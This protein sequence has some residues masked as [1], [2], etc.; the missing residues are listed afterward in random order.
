MKL[1]WL[2]TTALAAV[3]AAG[4]AQAA[5]MPVKA[6]VY[7]APFNWTGFYIGAHVGAGW[8]TKEWSAP[9]VNSPEFGPAGSYNLNGFLGGGQIGYNWQSG[10]AVFGIEADASL[11]DIKGSFFEG[12]ISSKIDSLGTVTAR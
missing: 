9:D 6:P 1:F 12:G 5:D 10:W 7:A 2:G 4:A 8:S 11:T 3:V